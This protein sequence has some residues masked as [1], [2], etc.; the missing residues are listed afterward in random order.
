MEKN[1]STPVSSDTEETATIIRA[2]VTE[3]TNAIAVY[4][5]GPSYMP[6]LMLKDMEQWRDTLATLIDG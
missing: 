3:M 2:L 4:Q 5:R 1:E 6:R